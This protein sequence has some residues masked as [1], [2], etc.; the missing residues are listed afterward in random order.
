MAPIG[1]Q[2][3]GLASVPLRNGGVAGR[4]DVEDR[5]GRKPPGRNADGPAYDEQLDVLSWDSLSSQPTEASA[6]S[7]RIQRLN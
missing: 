1:K 5:A 4:A 2:V 3:Q 6:F 7:R